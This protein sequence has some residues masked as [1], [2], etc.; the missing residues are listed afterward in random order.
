[1]YLH[2]MHVYTAIMMYKLFI[3]KPG[4]KRILYQSSRL[5]LSVPVA[6]T[7]KVCLLLSDHFSLIL[8]MF[9]KKQIALTIDFLLSLNFYF[10]KLNFVVS[11]SLL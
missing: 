2:L 6:V 5:C 9:C 4:R 10:K 8:L 7:V 3:A 1:M 11:V